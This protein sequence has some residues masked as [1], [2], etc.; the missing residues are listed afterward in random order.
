MILCDNRDHA[1]NEY[2]A[3]K[4]NEGMSGAV[5]LQEHFAELKPGQTRQLPEIRWQ[6][7]DGDWHSAMMIYRR[8]LYSFYQPVKSQNKVCH[9]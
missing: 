6:P 1:K 2:R 7:H 5:Y 3:A 8:V 9:Q 4:R